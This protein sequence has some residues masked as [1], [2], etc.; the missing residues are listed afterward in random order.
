MMQRRKRAQSGFSFMELMVT[1]I[2]IVVLAAVVMLVVRGFFT[3]AKETG[4]EG[5]LHSVKT[6]VDAFMIQSGKP[7]TED[8]LLPPAGEYA[9]IDFNASFDKGGQT[10]RFY[11]H[12]IGK[13]PRHW[14]E[15]VWR[16]DYA[17]L[18]S[19]DMP[20]QDY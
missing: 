15:G 13:L 17:A 2:I 3:K 18:V 7:P 6:A 4:L 8:G 20:S 9:L 1:L 16:L 5:D 14:D 12:F 19:V 11:P 10:L